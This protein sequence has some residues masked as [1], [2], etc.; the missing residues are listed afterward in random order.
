MAD[1]RGRVGNVQRMQTAIDRLPS[2]AG[3]IG[4]K[5]AGRRDGDKDPIRIASGQE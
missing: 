3:V 1:L 5:R 4:A 2:F